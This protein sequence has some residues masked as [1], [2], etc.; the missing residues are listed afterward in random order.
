MKN[1]DSEVRMERAK[2]GENKTVTS[3]PE[4]VVIKSHRGEKERNTERERE[5]ERE[6]ERERE[7]RREENDYFENQICDEYLSVK[8][9]E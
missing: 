7:R 1:M 5:R 4:K 9:R 6:S 2:Q 8:E 3:G